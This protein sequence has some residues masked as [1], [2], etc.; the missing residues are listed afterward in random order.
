MVS[1]N[2]LLVSISFL[3]IS[4]GTWVH[5]Q[6]PSRLLK[7]VLPSIEKE[8]DVIFNYAT[9]QLQDIHVSSKSSELSLTE[10]LDEYAKETG[11]VFEFIDDKKI[12]IKVVYKYAVLFFDE[13]TNTP[14]P[15]VRIFDSKN[16]SEAIR[17]SNTYGKV[18]YKKKPSMIQT[19]HINYENETVVLFSPSHK[20]F[21]VQLKRTLFNLD[22]V[23][24]QSYLSAGILQDSDGNFIIKPKQVSELPGLVTHDVL[25]SVQNLPQIFS[26]EESI[27]ELSVKG[28]TN[29]QN[30][31]LWNGTR[32]FQ[33]SHFFGLISA[34]NYNL[35]K[36]VKLYDNGTPARLDGSTSSTLEIKTIDKLPKKI[37]GG[38]GISLLSSDFY[39]K[40]PIGKKSG[41]FISAR[42]GLNDLFETPTY[43]K[44]ADKA[45]QNSI[46]NATSTIVN[47]DISRS[48]GLRFY[49]IEG[50]YV[51]NYNKKNTFKI[52]G[53]L[54]QDDLWYEEASNGNKRKSSLDQKSYIINGL[55]KRIIS[56]KTNAILSYGYSK[57]DLLAV[58]STYINNLSNTQKNEV[59]SGRTNLDFHTKFN[60]FLQ[61]SYGGSYEYMKVENSTQNRLPSFFSFNKEITTTASGYGEVKYTNN[62]LNLRFGVK[63]LHMSKLEKTRF[64][65]RLHFSYAPVKGIQIQLKGEQKSQYLTQVTDLQNNFL[66]VEKRRWYLSNDIEYP[67]QTSNQLEASLSYKKG[68]TLGIYGTAFYKEVKGITTQTQGFQ[69]QNQFGN[70]FGAYVSKGF[71]FH[72][73]YSKRG[74]IFWLSYAYAINNYTFE[75]FIPPT[76]RNNVDIRHRLVAGSKIDIRPFTFSVGMEYR[77]GAPYTSINEQTPII[78]SG[79]VNRL[80]YEGYNQAQLTEYFRL[81]CSVSYHFNFTPKVTSNITVGV[82]NLTNRKNI[83]NK[84]YRLDPDDNTQFSQIDIFGLRLTPNVAFRVDY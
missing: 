38:L 46:L 3:W 74:K 16:S 66:G 72:G 2:K 47:Q 17:Y 76:F 44:Y 78:Q 27:A 37:S 9:N 13:E 10:L 30:A 4:F 65:P 11:L 7:D 77:T 43:Q 23:F 29:D 71:M 84:I 40:T 12:T 26:R 75:G 5:A 62:K 41:L 82:T 28:G 22:E 33:A 25:K 70:H 20:V 18:F 42:R 67:L 6:V 58:N 1:L 56:P 36:E 48:Q 61:F 50:H 83:L 53:L 39:I 31:L 19:S 60:T 35:V 45:F 8:H 81:D 14:I 55:W 59:Y 80:N 68:N 15:Y 32:I 79:V 64:E 54:L 51:L 69:N 49:D 57:Y 52:Q 21:E 34:F 73:N 24:I 63:G